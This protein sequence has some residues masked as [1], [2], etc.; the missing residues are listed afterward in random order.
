MRLSFFSMRAGVVWGMR[1]INER[2][3]FDL[4]YDQFTQVEVRNLTPYPPTPRTSTSSRK[5]PSMRVPTG[6]L[7][8]EASTAEGFGVTVTPEVHK[9]S[10]A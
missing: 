6:G 1:I 7:M 10:L 5:H 3:E 9:I 4:I 2:L 8:G